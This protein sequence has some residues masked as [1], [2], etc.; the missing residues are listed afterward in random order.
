MAIVATET[1][2]E[3]VEYKHLAGYAKVKLV[4]FNPNAAEVQAITGRLPKE[5]P[6]YYGQDKNGNSRILM[7]FFVQVVDGQYAGNVYSIDTFLTNDKCASASGKIQVIDDCG[8]AQWITNEEF[9]SKKLPENSKLT[10]NKWRY[11][12]KGEEVAK[13]I[14]KVAYNSQSND[15]IG[16]K[17]SDLFSGKL[18]ELMSDM[19]AIIA[20][21]IEFYV[22]IGLRKREY[23]VD[24]EKKFAYNPIVKADKSF[25]L[26]SY[27]AIE[28]QLSEWIIKNINNDYSRKN[29]EMYV[30]AP[31]GEVNT[32]NLFGESAPAQSQ[33][34]APA[35]PAPAPASV[36]KVDDLPF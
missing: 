11:A 21:N 23:E 5:E 33:A 27:N 8:R 1:P 35:Q 4:A 16:W 2:R 13:H 12:Y 15:P 24:G 32:S 22:F 31:F 7:K 29:N 36:N 10:P 14:C 6:S 34:E 26:R 19:K 3:Q 9:N 25:I 28:N 20:K 30:I 18:D 17:M